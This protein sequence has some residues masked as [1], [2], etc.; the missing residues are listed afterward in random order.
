MSSKINTLIGR[1]AYELCRN[2]IGEILIEELNNQFNVL[3]NTYAKA[4]VTVEGN[5]IA[6]TSDNSEVIISLADGSFDN[7][8][9]GNSRG[10][11][12]F[13]VDVF[14]RAKSTALLDG[15][16]NAAYKC[17]ALIGIIRY[18]LKDPQ[19][20]TLGFAPPF[21]SNVTVMGIKIGESNK[22]DLNNT[23]AGR[24]TLSVTVNETNA[25]LTASL[26]AGYQTTITLGTSAQG[27]MYNPP[28]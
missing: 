26:I 14:C 3:G 28:I 20:R 9:V 13:N 27:Y 2:R 25:L 7:E 1:Q 6:E 19:Y 4:N 24:L 22:E 18:I 12:I 16:V 8:H 21:I 5:G 23:V 10:K 11:Y 17:Q 15:S